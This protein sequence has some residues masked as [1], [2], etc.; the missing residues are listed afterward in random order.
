MY[1]NGEK[2]SSADISRK[3]G[4]APRTVAR[5]LKKNGLKAWGRRKK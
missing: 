3:T 4:I 1:H 2:L 5:Y